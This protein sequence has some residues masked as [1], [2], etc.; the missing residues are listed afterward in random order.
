MGALI[1][2]SPLVSAERGRFD[3]DARIAA[4]PG[5]ELFVSVISV[6]ELLVGVHHAGMPQ[7]Q[8]AR[9]NWVESLLVRF[10]LL[11]V[12]LDIAREHARLSADLRSRGST[13]GVHDL[14]LAATCLVYDLA[15]ATGNVREFARV[16]G[17]RV[18][19]WR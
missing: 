8:E 9:R 14:W 19:L 18:E 7:R 10:D 13:I 17:L 1:D 16:P 2:T 15:I 5:E 4:Q 11:A 6:S 12:T 3:L